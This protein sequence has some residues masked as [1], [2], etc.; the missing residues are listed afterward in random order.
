MN[1]LKHE[2]PKISMPAMF[3]C[4]SFSSDTAFLYVRRTTV[5][6]RVLQDLITNV[7]G[8]IMSTRKHRCSYVLHQQHGWDTSLVRYTRRNHGHQTWWAGCP[9][10]RYWLW[11]GQIHWPRFFFRNGWWK[12]LKPY[13]VLKRVRTITELDTSGVIVALS[14]NRWM[15]VE[16]TKD[17][18]KRVWGSLNFERQLLVWDAYKC[19]ITAEVRSCVNR[20]TN[21]DVSVILWGL[22]SRPDPTHRQG[23]GVHGQDYHDNCEFLDSEYNHTHWKIPGI[24]VPY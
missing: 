10:L 15:N 5:Y 24:Q 9:S 3:G 14:K 22:T 20:Q 6:Q 2:E 23:F 13:V 19:H 4:R 16:L 17:W 8:F 7:V 1:L 12:Q 21:T 11:K 18:V